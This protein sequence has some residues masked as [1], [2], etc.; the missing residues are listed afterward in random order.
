VVV[1]V[2]VV[3]GGGEAADVLLRHVYTWC[4]PNALAVGLAGRG[5]L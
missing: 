5:A 4:P 2:V 1:V 3:C